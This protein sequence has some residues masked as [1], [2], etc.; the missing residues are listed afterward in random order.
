MYL[1]GLKSRLQVGLFLG[2]NTA[3]KSKLISNSCS[4]KYLVRFKWNT[5]FYKTKI[6]EYEY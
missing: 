1:I 2:L 4:I 6:F 3:V 5:K